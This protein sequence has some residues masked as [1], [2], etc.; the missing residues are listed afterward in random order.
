VGEAIAESMVRREPALSVFSLRYTAIRLPQAV[1]SRSAS[2][3]S[4]VWSLATYVR[5]EDAA[6]ATFLCCGVDRPGH[7]PLNIV[8]P[9]SARPWT[10]DEVAQCHGGMPSLRRALS[11]E[12]AMITSDRAREVL[13]FVADLPAP[14]AAGPAGAV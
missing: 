8:A 13:G 12:D 10:S 14:A 6:R 3:S 1:W 7:T 2:A 11:A 4:I 5:V 9:R